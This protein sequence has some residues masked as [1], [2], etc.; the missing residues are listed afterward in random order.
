MKIEEDV[1][2]D[3]ADVLIKP[4]RSE[5][6]SRAT[7]ELQRHF[8]FKYSSVELT[9]IP[10]IAANMDTTGS[11]AMSKTLGKLNC[12]TALHKFHNDTSILVD[13]FDSREEDCLKT[14]NNGDYEKWKWLRG[15]F[16][17]FNSA[18][19]CIDVAN[20]YTQN[21]VEFVAKV[22][23]QAPNSVIMAGNV[24]T[25]EMTQ[26]LLINGRADI[27]KLGIGPGSVCTTRTKTGVGYPQLSAI[28]ECA[29][30]AH[31]IGGHVCADGGIKESGDAAKAF[32]AG[33]D[34][35]M[36]G[37]ML[38][39][40]DE[41]EGEWEYEGGQK[42]KYI[43]PK[44]RERDAWAEDCLMTYHAYDRYY[45][46]STFNKELDG[47]W[48]TVGKKTSLRF[49]G[50]SSAEAMLQHHGEMADYKT[51]E[52]V[53]IEVPYKGKAEEVIKDIL[54]GLR[55]ACAYTGAKSLKDL[56]KCTT[57]IRTNRIK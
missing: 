23:E 24:A 56:P 44:E 57:F 46:V 34:F 26:E 9:S 1:K 6:A 20:G 42:Y 16:A 25:P 29:D 22:R 48:R 17:A 14:F 54:G 33:A 45:D 35:I 43:D 18:L 21:F 37:G 3:F 8:K 55:S 30:V 2:L 13:H 12:L 53:E 40:T 50:M 51:A 36:I 47:Q 52:G 5:A 7:V 31:G 11:I 28:A 15:E 41:C 32:G 10:I 39:G 27:V 38:A 19:I 4:K 49:H